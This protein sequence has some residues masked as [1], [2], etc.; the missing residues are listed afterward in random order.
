MSTPANEMCEDIRIGRGAFLNIEKM[1]SDSPD[2][3]DAFLK[4]S[5]DYKV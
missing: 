1:L 2:S 4:A 5:L 3:M